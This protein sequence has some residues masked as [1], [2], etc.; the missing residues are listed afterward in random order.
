MD[1]YAQKT[2]LRLAVAPDAVR[3]EFKKLWRGR[4]APTE[5]EDEPGETVAQGQRPT[6][7]EYWLLKLLLLHED[8]VEWLS[9]NLDVQWLQHPVIKQ[10]VSKRLAAHREQ[11]WASLPAFLDQCE[12][13]DMQNLITEVAAEDRPIPNPVQQVADVVARLR[14]QFIDRQLLALIQR[15]NLPE[16]DDAE[17]LALLREQQAMRLLKRQPLSPVA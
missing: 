11:T 2:A 13:P 9:I 4:S 17:R 14:N 5:P 7:Q 6:P 12:S 15:A 8:L 16:T 1:K 3:A 10:I